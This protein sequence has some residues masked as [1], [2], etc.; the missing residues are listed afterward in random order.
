MHD[1]SINNVKTGDKYII[2]VIGIMLSCLEIGGYYYFNKIGR[3]S[4]RERV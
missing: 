1:K 3:A 2:V 4:C